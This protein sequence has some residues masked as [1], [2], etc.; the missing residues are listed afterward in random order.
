MATDEFFLGGAAFN[1]GAL[2]QGQD[3]PIGRP[4]LWGVTRRQANDPAISHSL[5]IKK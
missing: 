1:E 5:L 2:N 3:A 4:Q